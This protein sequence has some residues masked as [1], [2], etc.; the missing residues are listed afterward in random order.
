MLA[1]AE[2]GQGMPADAEA[3][4]RRAIALDPDNA[5]FPASLAELLVQQ[6][7][8]DEALVS[9][10]Q[11]LTLDP[12]DPLARLNLGMILLEQGHLQQAATE[13]AVA[14][15]SSRDPRAHAMLGVALARLGRPDEARQHLRDAL[16]ID[17]SYAPAREELD[18]LDTLGGQTP[19][20]QAR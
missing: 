11:A 13:L 3:H 9:A 19:G 17:P 10:R 6:G 15:R 2:W 1:A 12:A 20:V 5:A 7:R 16:A 14:A 8:Y 4:F 18:R